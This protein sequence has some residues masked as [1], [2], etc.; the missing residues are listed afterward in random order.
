[1]V[2]V[3]CIS[4]FIY[5]TILNFLTENVSIALKTVDTNARANCENVGASDNTKLNKWVEKSFANQLDTL[6]TNTLICG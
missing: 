3:T 2:D 5:E 1:M 6:N 4:V